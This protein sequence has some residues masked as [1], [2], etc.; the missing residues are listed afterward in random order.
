M[1]KLLGEGE[2]NVEC[3]EDK[4]MYVDFSCPDGFPSQSP[5]PS[6]TPAPTDIPTRVPTGPPTFSCAA[7]GYD[8]VQIDELGGDRSGLWQI[9]GC[10]NDLPYY[11]HTV[12]DLN[13]CYSVDRRRWILSDA[14]CGDTETSMVWAF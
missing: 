5:T 3:K 7:N 9:A 10:H 6:P 8:C 12:S 11:S 4:G 13:M 14:L 1:G 2:Y